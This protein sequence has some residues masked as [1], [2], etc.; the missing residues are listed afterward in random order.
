MAHR[1]KKLKKNDI[2]WHWQSNITNNSNYNWHIVSTYL[3]KK[4]KERKRKK[5]NFQSE[6]LSWWKAGKIVKLGSSITMHDEHLGL[7]SLS[8]FTRT[9][10]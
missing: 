2:A 9:L 4:K 3:K 5:F 6:K 10:N 7:W 1:H 8:I